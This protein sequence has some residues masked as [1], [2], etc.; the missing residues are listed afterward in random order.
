MLTIP[1]LTIA[2]GT[3]VVARSIV[4]NDAEYDWMYDLTKTV[5]IYVP[6][7][8][9]LLFA[10]SGC[11]DNDSSNLSVR[12]IAIVTGP[13]TADRID[14]VEF[15]GANSFFEGGQ[16]VDMQY[17][18]RIVE[19]PDQSNVTL[20]NVDSARTGFHPDMMGV[21]EVELAV[22]FAGLTSDPVRF[23]VDVNRATLFAQTFETPGLGSLI[24]EGFGASRFEVTDGVLRIFPGEGGRQRGFVYLA[25]S[26]VTGDYDDMLG[27]LSAPLE[28][29]FSV[30]N[31]D[32]EI[33]GACNNSY[34]LAL[35]NLPDRADG[36]NFAYELSGG[37]FV[38]DRIRFSRRTNSRSPFGNTG[39]V[40]IEE[41][42]GLGNTPEIGAFRIRYDPQSAEWQL[43][44]EKGSD[45]IDPR[46]ITTLI[47]QVSDDTYADRPL[48]YLL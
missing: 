19:R 46:E 16:P 26:S 27:N 10:V 38:G 40:L 34:N 23:T 42:E 3:T 31:Q 47:G 15:S 18:W 17:A 7:I 12:P 30:S 45:E 8:L 33:C 32:G 43:F 21:Y 6:L 36:R 39:E 9:A 29:S 41:I 28:L 14:F 13:V 25:L 11:S 20:V 48:P 35:A 2:P 37:G 5:V 44:F 24:Y 4:R 1:E 22:S